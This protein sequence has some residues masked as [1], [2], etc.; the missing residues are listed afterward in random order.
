[1]MLKRAFLK[2]IVVIEKQQ[3][4]F[5]LNILQSHIMIPLLHYSIIIVL[6]KSGISIELINIPLL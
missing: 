4:A 2:K 1:M 6:N 5:N 3:D